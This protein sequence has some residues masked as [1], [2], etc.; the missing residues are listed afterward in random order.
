MGLFDGIEQAQV[1]QGGIYFLPGNYVVEVLKCITLRSRK[2]EDLFIAEC[3]IHESDNPERRPGVKASWYVNF[4]NDAALG[5]IKGFVAAANGID[6]GNQGEVDKEVD[7]EV[8]E[9]VV[10]DQNP[11]AGTWLL[12]SCANTKTRSGADFTLH[13]WAPYAKAPAVTAKQYETDP[14]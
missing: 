13:R 8:C 7:A 6:P 4:K 5:N 12:L 9:Y 11:L 3:L 1:G 2:R 14:F 10:S